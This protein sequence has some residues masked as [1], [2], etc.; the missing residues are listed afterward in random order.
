MQHQVSSIKKSSRIKDKDFRKLVL[1]ITPSRNQDCQGI[2]LASFQEDAKYE[3]VGQDTRSQGGKDDQDKQGK[4]L[5]I[6]KLKTKSKDNDKGSRSKIAQHEGTSLQQSK[7]QE[8]YLRTQQQSN[9]KDLT[10]G[11]IVSLKLTSLT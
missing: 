1:K 8:Q 11:K 4:Y 2:L 3:H 10:S 5:K 9:L 7:V 6:S